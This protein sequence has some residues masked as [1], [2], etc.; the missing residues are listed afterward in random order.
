MSPPDAADRPTGP[1][2]LGRLSAW[3]IAYAVDMA[4]AALITYW[5]MAAVF[6]R[7]GHGA[8]SDLIGGLWA[9]VAAVYVFRETRAKSL[10]AS[11]GRV[12]A[13]GVSFGLCLLYLLV[14]PFSS[15]GLAALLTCGTLIMMALGRR[16][17]IGLTAVTTA[18]IMLVAAIDPHDAWRQPLLRLMDT[19]IG[20]AVG[21]VCKWAGSFV[22][23]KIVGEEVR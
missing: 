19:L 13:T 4:L 5:I 2:R 10:S 23:F 12:I 6:L 21:V 3:D 7:F 15:L 14:F 18:V 22:F 9:I 16:E 17:D 1:F 20:V 8:S 11:I